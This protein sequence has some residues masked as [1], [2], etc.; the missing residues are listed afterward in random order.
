[1]QCKDVFDCNCLTTV[2]VEQQGLINSL[3]GSLATDLTIYKYTV[4]T[5][6]I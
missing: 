6:N 3:D 4:Y 5:T 1:M 2:V